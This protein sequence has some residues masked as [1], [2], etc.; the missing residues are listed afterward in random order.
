MRP[1]PRLV[2]NKVVLCFGQKAEGRSVSSLV[3][4]HANFCWKLWTPPPPDYLYSEEENELN[5]V[6]I[7]HHEFQNIECEILTVFEWMSFCATLT[8]MW[9]MTTWSVITLID[10]NK[11]ILR[12]FRVYFDL[13]RPKSVTFFTYNLAICCKNH[14]AWVAKMKENLIICHTVHHHIWHKV[15]LNHE[16]N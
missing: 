1:V 16:I 9:S 3:I 5:T 7:Y 2:G 6:F 4:N 8:T 12:S 13:F 11:L 10:I 14:K 15:I